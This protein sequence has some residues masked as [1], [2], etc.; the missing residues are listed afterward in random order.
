MITIKKMKLESLSE[1]KHSTYFPMKPDSLMLLS[2]GHTLPPALITHLTRTE[3]QTEI[4]VQ[5]RQP[6]ISPPPSNSIFFLP[7]DI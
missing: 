4:E 5:K 6:L 2:K 1:E 3:T 7:T